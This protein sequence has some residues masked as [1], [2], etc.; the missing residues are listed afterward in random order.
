MFRNGIVRLTNSHQ[1]TK[2][3]TREYSPAERLP[4]TDH[5]KRLYPQVEQE[6]TDE[7]FPILKLM[8]KR[9]NIFDDKPKRVRRRS[10]YNFKIREQHMKEDQDWP[11]VWPT[12]KTFVPSAV[13]LPLRQSFESK[14][15]AVP[16]FKYANT[17]LLKITNFLH[18]TPN[19]IKKHCLALEKFCTKWPDNLDTDEQVRSHFPVT[20]VTR[21]YV[22]SSPSIRDPRARIVK[23][24]VIVKDL[25]LNARDEDKLIELARHRYNKETGVLT[26]TVDACPVRIQNQDYSDYLLSALYFESQEHQ[27]WEDEKVDED[28]LY[29][30][31][32]DDYRQIVE[33]KFGLN[34]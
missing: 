33:Q 34:K 31:D 14:P 26:I 16:R 15:G 13:P 18:L 1:M 21:D 17:E 12:A 30:I 9:K 23:L 32:L 10:R 27:S 4:L 7:G 3:I 19:A 28:A 25:K 5:Q 11:S 6:F 8:P 29:R 24:K 22:H 2:I 20:Y